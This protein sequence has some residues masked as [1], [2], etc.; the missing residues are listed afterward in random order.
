M[1][2]DGYSVVAAMAHGEYEK[3]FALDEGRGEAHC[4][5]QGVT[6]K[7]VCVR[8]GPGTQVKAGVLSDTRSLFRHVEEGRVQRCVGTP[9]DVK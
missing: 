1:L 6:A 8:R 4:E 3:V 7:S 5:E 9:L 2:F